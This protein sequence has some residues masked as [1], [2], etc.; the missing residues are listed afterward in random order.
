[1]SC[2]TSPTTRYMLREDFNRGIRSL[3]PFGLVYDVLIYARQLANTI[4]FVDRHPR[5]AVRG[6]PHR[7][8]GHQ[9]VIIR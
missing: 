9:P 1:M 2:K 7:Q 5:S 3:K 8:A 4:R 6:G